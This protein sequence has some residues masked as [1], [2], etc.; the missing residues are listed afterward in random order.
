MSGEALRREVAPRPGAPEDV[1][2]ATGLDD[3]SALERAAEQIGEA[4]RQQPVDATAEQAAV[5]A[6]R[7]ART[8]GDL[9]LRTRH[10]DDWRPRTQKQRWARGGAVALVTSALLGGIAFASIRATDTQQHD[11][12]D[13]GTSH[14]TRRP[15]RPPVHPPG[16]QASAPVT[17]STTPTASAQH[18]ETA[19]DLEAHCR[20]YERTKNRGHALNATAWQRLV[21][22]AGGEQQVAAYCAELTSSA[23][24][25]TPSPGKANKPGKGQGK[26]SAKAKP[27]KGS[28]NRP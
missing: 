15:P 2:A 23:D 10:R 24:E 20:A 27:S 8:A 17:P 3:A 11:T 28:P 9:T 7:S 18:P 1:G 6:F 12:P 14:S 21:Q 22:A 4:L 16:G 13:P 5:A 25:T 19:K 26:P